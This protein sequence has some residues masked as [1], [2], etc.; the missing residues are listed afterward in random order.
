MRAY[1]SGIQGKLYEGS[2]RGEESIWAR[3][4]MP[5]LG[6]FKLNCSVPNLNICKM[7]TKI[8]TEIYYNVVGEGHDKKKSITSTSRS[9][10]K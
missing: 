6:L 2:R 5:I 7:S 10:L 3:N 1:Y 8:Y 9:K 4:E